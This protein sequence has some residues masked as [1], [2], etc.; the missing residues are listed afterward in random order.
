[1]GKITRDLQPPPADL[2]PCASRISGVH[3]LACDELDVVSY[4]VKYLAGGG[5]G[6]DSSHTVQQSRSPKHESMEHRF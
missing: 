3:K 6:Q 2:D 1:M 4:S 5:G